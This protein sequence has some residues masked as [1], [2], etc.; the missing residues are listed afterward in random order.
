MAYQKA[1][2][3]EYSRI[4]MSIIG[5]EVTDVGVDIEGTIMVTV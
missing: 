4:C 5:S 1:T 3:K 2:H